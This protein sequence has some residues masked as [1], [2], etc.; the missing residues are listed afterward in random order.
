MSPMVTVFSFVFIVIP[1]SIYLLYL[2]FVTLKNT[3]SGKK[4]MI[5][6]LH[7]SLVGGILVLD[8]NIY[9][10]RF[11]YIIVLL[12]LILSMVGMRKVEVK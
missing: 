1:I 7:V 11:A 5:L 9:F 10:N 12:G 8:T 4:Y 6:G 2:I 3:E